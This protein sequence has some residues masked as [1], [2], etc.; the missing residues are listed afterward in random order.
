MSESERFAA[1]LKAWGPGGS[2]KKIPSTSEAFAYCRNLATTH[3]ENFPVVSWLLPKRLHQHFYNIYAYCRW[4]DDLG[5]EVG[6]RGRSLEL[7]SWW[8]GE[9]TACYAGEN[10]HPVFV[11]LESTIRE[12]AIPS[13]P[14]TDLVSAF[15]QDQHTLQ[16][17]TFELL[18]D[19]CRRSANPVGRLVLYL[20]QEAKPG[21]FRWSDSICTGL[22]L[23]NFWQDVRRDLSI[24]RIYLPQE[25]L[26]RFSC[27][28]GDLESGVE[29]AGFLELMKFEVDRARQF[30]A[31]WSNP[32]APE[33]APLDYRVQVDIELF[34]A[35][36]KRILDRIEKIGY[37]VLAQRPVVSKRDVVGLFVGC[38][39]RSAIRKMAWMLRRSVR[40]SN[41]V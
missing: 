7:L 19:Y 2:Q 38:A 13:E 9:L 5:D 28:M 14:F 39:M 27:T 29:N 6:D 10:R 34:A 25:D 41:G 32:Q 37:R 4:S 1:E 31:P 33:L 11:A 40:Q 12:F 18:L 15:E 8:R 26:K 16:Y 17:E 36:G 35:G 24:G 20:C 22:Q 30:L 21:N 3:Y 23:A